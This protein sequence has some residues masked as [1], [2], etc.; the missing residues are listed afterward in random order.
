M[1]T[2]LAWCLVMDLL[3]TVD[4]DLTWVQVMGLASALAS[5]LATEIRILFQMDTVAIQVMGLVDSVARYM[6]LVDLDNTDTNISSLKKISHE[7]FHCHA[8]N[9]C[10]IQHKKCL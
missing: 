6:V 7:N 5:A 9:M 8:F 1:A 3:T 10:G 4:M 2:V